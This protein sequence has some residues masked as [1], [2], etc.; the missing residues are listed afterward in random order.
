MT[1]RNPVQDHSFLVRWSYGPAATVGNTG[2]N[3]A[4][5]GDFSAAVLVDAAFGFH[6]I[7]LNIGV[8][9]HALHGSGSATPTLMVIHRSVEELDTDGIGILRLQANGDPSVPASGR[10]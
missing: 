3:L 1:R 2:Q 7:A 4:L 9:R 8:E 6:R 5:T 10:R